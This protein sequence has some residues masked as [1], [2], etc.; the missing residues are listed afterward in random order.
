MT[1]RSRLLVLLLPTLSAFILLI[2]LFFYFNWSHEIVDNFKVITSLGVDVSRQEIDQKLQN[3]LFMIFL[4]S[5]VTVLM[6]ITAVFFIADKISKPVR[7][8]NQAALDIAAGE[9]ETNIQVEGPK[10]IVEL[11]NTLN[12]MSECLADQMLRLKES[13]L[14]RERLYGEH[15]CALLLQHYML[16]K[17]VDDFHFSDLKIFLASTNLSKS[18]KGICLRYKGTELSEFRLTII[19]AKKAGFS[20][21][22]ELNR[23]SLLPLQELTDYG[24]IECF[25]ENNFIFRY[26]SQ[27]LH[28]PLVWSLAEEQ[29]VDIGQGI[30][31]HKNK[32]LIFLY[33][34]AL[35]DHFITEKA[36]QTW[37]GKVLRHFAKDGLNHL[38]T[39]LS[40]ELNY[41]ARRASIKDNLYILALYL[42]PK[43]E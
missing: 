40:N 18:S 13:S 8:L 7:Q 31:M 25:F 37:L 30:S 14:I 20:A 39:I 33:N 15:E 9:Y 43:S 17:V 10:E 22:Y 4:G 11:A 6:I 27:E 26:S 2:A 32:Y 16:Q 5:I 41:L 35:L 19:E 12:T 1:I 24:Y 36:I 34:S 21:L 28:S 38:H 23:H 3:A 42:P 29:F